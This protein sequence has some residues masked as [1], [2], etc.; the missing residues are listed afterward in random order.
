MSE[1]DA[2]GLMVTVRRDRKGWY[3]GSHKGHDV[4]VADEKDA[5]AITM[6]EMEVLAGKYGTQLVLH[7]VS[8]NGQPE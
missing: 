1:I 7:V 8:R 4:F 5:E 6:D 3:A 2:T